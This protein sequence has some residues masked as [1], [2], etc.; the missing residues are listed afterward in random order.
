V[1]AAPGVPAGAVRAGAGE[2]LAALV[3]VCNARAEQAVSGEAAIAEE[4][5]R[6]SRTHLRR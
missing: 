5:R 3:H 1:V 4:K 2:L 6:R